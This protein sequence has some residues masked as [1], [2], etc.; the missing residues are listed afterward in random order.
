MYIYRPGSKDSRIDVVTL[1]NNSKARILFDC[2]L[3]LV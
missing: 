3:T 1:S 2:P